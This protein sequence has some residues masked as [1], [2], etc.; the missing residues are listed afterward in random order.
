MKYCG[1]AGKIERM[2]SE[3]RIEP[4]KRVVSCPAK[5]PEGYH[6]ETG[7][8]VQ[9]VDAIKIHLGLFL[10]NIFAITSVSG[11]VAALHS[12]CCLRPLCLKQL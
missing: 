12:W 9:S 11:E 4:D 1:G 2:D 10:V 7:I 5:L 8:S 6:F 3:V